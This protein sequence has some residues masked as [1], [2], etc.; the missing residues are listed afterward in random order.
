MSNNILIKL[1]V[2]EWPVVD[3][4]TMSD[5]EKEPSGLA[6]KFLKTYAGFMDTLHHVEKPIPEDERSWLK[7]LSIMGIHENDPCI[8]PNKSIDGYYQT[9]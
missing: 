2:R 9:K 1:F 6:Y 7:K 3:P 8:Y 5:T 4:F